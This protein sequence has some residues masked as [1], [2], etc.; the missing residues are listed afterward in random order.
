[1][2]E[3]IDT[4]IPKSSREKNRQA[5][6]LVLFDLAIYGHHP[7]YIQYL[8]QYWCEQQWQGHLDIVVSPQFLQAHGEVVATAH[9]QK[10]INFVPIR[11]AE[12]TALKPRHSS[13]SR[14][15]RAW[16][17]WQLL[18]QYVEQLGA[19][20]C[21]IM[22]FDPYQLPLALGAKPPCRF[23]GIYFR[24][25]LH[26]SKFPNYVQTWKSQLQQW[27]EKWLLRKTLQNSRLQTLFTL[28]PFAVQ[29]INQFCP[30]QKV[31][32][33]SDPVVI[34][35]STRFESNHL[36]E[37]LGVESGRKVFLLFGALT[38]R[39]GIYQLLEAVHLLPSSLCEKLCLAF[40][41]K[42]S[43]KEQ[44]KLQAHIAALREVQPVQVIETYKFICEQQVPVYFQMADVVLAIY[45]QHV[46]MSG[47]L[48]L[49]A[50]A[51][52]PVLSSDYG[53]MGEMTRR[54]QLG[55]VVDSTQP[56]EIV[57]GLALFLL[58]S[59]AQEWDCNQMKQFAAQNSPQRFAQ[60]ILE[61]I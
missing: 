17:E 34:P 42:A 55:L 53:L 12:E 50:A 1:M 18:C 23:S 38:R 28:D 29:A 25:T 59:P 51:Q 16:Q 24:P 39:K 8:V 7:A 35:D 44:N 37:T 49:A 6:K 54:H 60:T 61:N 10:N 31:I 22:Y 20:H 46:G 15:H 48:L 52:K 26:Y 30:Q 27:R 3:T 19:N 11:V 13:L 58:E 2:S 4:Q 32:H 41:G 9:S 5:Q 57:K 43:P 45:Q 33:L 56:Q 40:V 47:I 14:H 36:R 21:L